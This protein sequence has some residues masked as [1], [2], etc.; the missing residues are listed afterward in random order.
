M[1]CK[2]TGDM[3]KT[4]DRGGTKRTEIQK[5]WSIRMSSIYEAAIRRQEA[6]QER[7][8]ERQHE[9]EFTVIHYVID[10]VC[11]LYNEL[12]ALGQFIM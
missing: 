2:K 3:R 10:D 5:I 12:T 11:G 6:R 1:S 7:M 8:T 9:P 4:K